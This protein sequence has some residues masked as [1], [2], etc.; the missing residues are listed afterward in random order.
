MGREQI[1]V[2]GGS[3]GSFQVVT[4][5]L[6][7]LPEGF[8]LPIL[9]CLHR[10]KHVR[11]GFVEA[12]SQRSNLPVIEPNDKDTVRSG[13][14]YLAP[15]NYHMYVELGGKIQ[16]TTEEPVNHSRPSIDLTFSSV[17][18]AYRDGVV[19]IVLSGANCDGA[20]GLRRVK[21]LGGITIVQSPA[22]SAV[23]T[24]PEACLDE[25]NVDKQL[26]PKGIVEYL[27][28]LVPKGKL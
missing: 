13:I 7:S 24:M 5:I 16:L 8:P 4:H 14:A 20:K 25:C 18:R 27:L 22:H 23:R 9:L 11:S 12:L 2:I 26:S 6:Q 21:R 3:A 1:V 10:L 17:A 19:G 15:S 28:S